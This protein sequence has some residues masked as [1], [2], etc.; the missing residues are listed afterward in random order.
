MLFIFVCQSNSNPLIIGRRYFD[1]LYETLELPTYMRI[2]K[3]NETGKM[4]SIN[5]CLH[6]LLG[7]LDDP[8]DSVIFGPSTT[9][10][11]ERWWREVH[12]K[13][14]TFFK[15]Q[16]SSLLRRAE[17][18]PHNCV[19]RQLLAYVYI[20]IVQRECDSFIDNW[21]NHRIRHQEK[22]E[23]PTGVPDHMYFIPEQKGANYS[24]I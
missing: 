1:F 14:E 5:A 11:I 4:A 17:Y 19:D 10:K 22:M 12:E 6:G 23:I 7:E 24:I 9:N 2:D 8:V 20:P 21:N 16:L 15:V 13:L 3:G 18:D